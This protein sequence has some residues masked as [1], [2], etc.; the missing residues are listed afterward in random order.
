MKLKDFL[1]KYVP[2][3]RPILRILG[4]KPGTAVDRGAQ[5]LEKIEE[6]ERKL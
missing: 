1:H 3:L 4:L 2:I 5:I 6:A